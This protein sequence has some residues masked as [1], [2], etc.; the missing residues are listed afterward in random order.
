MARSEP[1]GLEYVS[2]WIAPATAATVNACTGY[3][4]RNTTGM[5]IAATSGSSRTRTCRAPKL[6]APAAAA[7]TAPDG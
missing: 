3:L 5:T 2:T 4:R 6:A 1:S 7:G